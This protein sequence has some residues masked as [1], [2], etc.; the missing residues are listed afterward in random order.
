MKAPSGLAAVHI[1]SFWRLTSTTCWWR[2]R[3]RTSMPN[4]CCNLSTPCHGIPP[5][6]Y[7]MVHC[8]SWLS[9]ISGLNLYQLSVGKLLLWF[10]WAVGCMLY[11]TVRQHLKTRT[12]FP[13]CYKSCVSYIFQAAITM[14]M[15]RTGSCWDD[16]IGNTAHYCTKQYYLNVM[17]KKNAPNSAQWPAT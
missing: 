7:I 1:W 17:P 14:E 5:N 16:P 4:H 13:R 15:S 8:T 6:R 11:N 9:I 2:Y 3:P 12:V 10:D